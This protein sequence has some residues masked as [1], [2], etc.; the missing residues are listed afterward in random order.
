MQIYGGGNFVS[1]NRLNITAHHLL[2]V[3]SGGKLTHKHLGYRSEK[4]RVG[5]PLQSTK[6]PGKGTDSTLGASGA[7]YAG[8]GGSGKATNRVGGFYG[9]LYTPW[10]YGSAGGFGLHHGITRFMIS[11]ASYSCRVL[12]R[13]FLLKRFYQAFNCVMPVK[14]S[15][16]FSTL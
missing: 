7:G 14:V 6:G 16:M 12:S 15:C 11:V 3:Y 10:Q 9:S 5:T 2:A 8:T 4:G 13:S 1:N